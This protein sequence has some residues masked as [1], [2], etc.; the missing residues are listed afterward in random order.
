MRSNDVWISTSEERVRRVFA[1]LL[2][3]PQEIDKTP[4]YQ[5]EETAD[6]LDLNLKFPVEAFCYRYDKKKQAV[7]MR[8]V[9]YA[10]V[11]DI[12]DVYCQL[13]PKQNNLELFF[14]VSAVFKKMAEEQGLPILKGHCR[15]DYRSIALA[16][17]F[18]PSMVLK[19]SH[20]LKLLTGI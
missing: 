11:S 4:K 14:R 19:E 20:P 18:D 1:L 16:V 7:T 8:L 12:C 10:L 13:N 9:D 6:F 5:L 17:L 3:T 15:A 2:M